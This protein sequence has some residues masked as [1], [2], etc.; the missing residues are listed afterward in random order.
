MSYCSD[1][2]GDEGSGRETEQPLVIVQRPPTV[3]EA[4]DQAWILD[5]IDVPGGTDLF[6]RPY[7]YDP[8]RRVL[9][10][11]GQYVGAPAGSPVVHNC[12][13][14]WLVNEIR[15]AF[16][17]EFNT[18]GTLRLNPRY[19]VTP[20]VVD[21]AHRVICACGIFVGEEPILLVGEED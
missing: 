3:E 13:G 12:P 5:A 1:R 9:C 6:L 15:G 17:V 16:T 19:T 7:E 2:P 14:S 8:R 11:C 21:P 10:S 20:F 4:E 18:D